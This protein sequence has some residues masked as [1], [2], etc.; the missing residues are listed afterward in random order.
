MLAFGLAFVGTFVLGFSLR[1]DP[2]ALEETLAFVDPDAFLDAL[3]GTGSSSGEGERGRFL[4]ALLACG[5]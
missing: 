1:S 4:H 2:R 5:K 3:R